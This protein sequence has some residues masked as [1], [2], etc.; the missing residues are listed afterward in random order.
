MAA[1][2]EVNNATREADTV[3]DGQI[4]PGTRTKYLRHVHTFVRYVENFERH[5]GI[6]EL[7][8]FDVGTITAAEMKRFLNYVSVK[9]TNG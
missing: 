3:I 9:R 5:D 1:Q 7:D 4:A 2:Q 6:L 8:Q